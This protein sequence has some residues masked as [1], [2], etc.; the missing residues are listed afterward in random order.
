MTS[1]NSSPMKEIVGWVLEKIKIEYSFVAKIYPLTLL[2]AKSKG[3]EGSKFK[4]GI[5]TS[6]MV[7]HFIPKWVK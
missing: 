1:I 4:C 2:L 6:H 5:D 7:T 3:P